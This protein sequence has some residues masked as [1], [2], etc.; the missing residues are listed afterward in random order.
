MVFLH[1]LHHILHYP[2]AGFFI[3]L[4]YNQ[5]PEVLPAGAVDFLRGGGSNATMTIQNGKLTPLPFDEMMDPNTGRTEVRKV[6]IESFIYESAYKFMVRMKPQD[7]K[8]AV[9]LARMANE[10]NL[11]ADEFKARYGYLIGIA[12]RPF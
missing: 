12:P 9:L 7:A 6:N 2:E 8:D 4:Y 11:S 1:G 5:R 3:C 10:T